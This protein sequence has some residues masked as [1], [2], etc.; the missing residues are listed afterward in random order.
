MV[1][2]WVYLPCDN[3]LSKAL[4][5]VYFCVIF[6]GYIY[7][8]TVKMNELDLLHLATWINLSNITLSDKKEVSEDYIE[9]DTLFKHSKT[10]KNI[11]FKATYIWVKETK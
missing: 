10:R 7:F 8:Q 3:S 4:W 11:L 5:S 9:Y 2:I 1:A 6:P